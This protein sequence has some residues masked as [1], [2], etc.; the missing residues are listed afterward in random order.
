MNLDLFRSKL[1]DYRRQTGYSQ[2][3]L[4]AEVG[5]H[6]TVLS[7][8]LNN[9]NDA[10][11][12][13]P[14]IKKIIQ[15]L[16]SWEAISTRQQALELLE[17][18]GLKSSSFSDKDWRETPLNLLETIPLPVE[19]PASKPAAPPVAIQPQPVPTVPDLPAHNLPAQPTPLIGR[20]QE[21]AALRE[22]LQR[23]E[24]QLL[25]LIGPGG[26]GKSRLAVQVAS[27]VVSE[28]EYG[29][30]FIALAAVPESHMV[31][32][33]IAQTL[34]IKEEKGQT[35]LESLK[36]YLANRQML[37]ILDN[38]EQ[39]VEAAPT[40]EALL[41][42]APQLK[43]LVTSRVLLRL[44]G[45]YEFGVPPLTLPAPQPDHI[46]L[47][48]E[49]LLG[50]DAVQLFLQRARA[51]DSNF[52]LTSQN[53]SA[54]IEVCAQ[55]DGLPL[56]IELAAARTKLF[57]PATLLARLTGDQGGSRSSRLSVLNG[58]PQ[59]SPARQRTLR[60]TLEW[61]YNL[62]SLPERHLFTQLATF[63]GGFTYE[64][65]EAI[66]EYEP[67][68]AGDNGGDVMDGLVSLLDKSMLQRQM[69]DRTD[70]EPRFIMLETLREYALE[71]RDPVLAERIAARHGAYYA[72]MAEQA[73][74]LLDGPQQLYWVSRL[75]AETAN[76]RAIL[77]RALVNEAS[78][79]E[80]AQSLGL[81][82]IIYY[83]WQLRGYFSEGRRWLALALQRADE[84]G[85]DDLRV[86]A[87]LYMGA[88]VLAMLQSDHLLARQYYEQALA[89]KQ[90]QGD[91]KGV[92][93]VYNNLANLSD[94]QGD[95]EKAKELFLQSLVLRQEI[96]DKYGVAISLNNLGVNA[97]RLG[98]YEE[99]RDYYERSLALRR[100]LRDVRGT[101]SVTVNLG[102]LAKNQRDYETA[103]FY[104]HEALRLWQEIG[105]PSSIAG[106]LG[107]LAILAME[108][109][110]WEQARPLL[111]QCLLIQQRLG[112]KRGIG[113]S[114]LNIGYLA[115]GLKN[116]GAA[117]FFLRQAH[118]I[119]EE[120]GNKFELAEC[121][122]AIAKLPELTPD[123][124][125]WLPG[126]TRT[127]ADPNSSQTEFSP[128]T[129]DQVIKY[130]LEGYV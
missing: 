16:A 69:S 18:T 120:G 123:A 77:T 79:E 28:F 31:E 13:N 8:K 4:A 121:D 48:P 12:T 59:N 102:V 83:Y 33:T 125:L 73:D 56:A 34:K 100:E 42:A 68:M 54:V 130:A 24:V 47:T 55:L 88:G 50:Y 38:F 29:V 53:A 103:S 124:L 49:M 35:T 25:T 63:A 112:Y 26:I 75:E 7:A 97:K 14:E 19:P 76:Y 107:N 101:A 62:L 96:G 118:D 60:N 93:S 23:P 113:E 127:L 40:V 84:I 117:R 39:I 99:A 78:P 51:V 20:S 30:C 82:G 43:I 52:Q 22:L 65:A 36:A 57:S 98:N 27:E 64:A 106:V 6:H 89:V 67:G 91:T 87:K 58:G 1:R 81:I 108:Q 105:E 17:L 5:L 116:Y 41:S 109:A 90:A 129:L 114:L 115:Q 3:D 37:L 104:L 70:S 61:S 9:S 21:I 32:T 95:L 2:Q 126:P 119:L 92:A 86:L 128:L 74:K 80:V 10:K 71:Q 94:D 111:M 11:L 66:L 110:Q 85:F 72:A 122:A 15:V 46:A 45:E 44:Y